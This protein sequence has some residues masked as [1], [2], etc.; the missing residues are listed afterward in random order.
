MN[1]WEG[2]YTSGGGMTDGS[3]KKSPFKMFSMIAVVLLV[4]G[5]TAS[6]FVAQQ[7]TENRSR[8]S[9]GGDYNNYNNCWSNCYTPT[10]TPTPKPTA[11]PTSTPTSTPTPVVTTSPTG[12]S[13]IIDNPNALISGS[14]TIGTS[15]IDKYGSDYRYTSG[16]S[17]SS[18][19]RYTPLIPTTGQYDVYEFHPA[20]LNRSSSAQHIISYSGG[21]QTISVNQQTNG[22]K[23]NFL[24]RFSFAQGSGGYV[25]ITNYGS[26]SYVVMADAIKFVPS[27]VIPTATPVPSSST[28]LALNKP[29]TA[30]SSCSTAE[31]PSQAVNGSWTGGSGDKWCS[32]GTNGAEWL[33]VDLGAFYNVSSFTIRHA[34]AGGEPTSYN[35]KSYT[36]QVSS[37]KVNWTTVVNIT[38]NT[39]NVSTNTISP[40]LARYVKLNV[41]TPEQAYADGSARIYEFEVYGSLASVTPTLIPTATPTPGTGGWPTATPTPR[42][43]A[44][45]TPV[46]TATP[47]PTATSTVAPTLTSWP[48]PTQKPIPT[49]V[50]IPTETP[51]PGDTILAFTVGLHGIG[52]GGD[53]TNPSSIGNMYPVHPQ[54][55]A[56]ADIYNTLNQLVETKQFSINFDSVSGKFKGDLNMGSLASGAYSVRIKPDQFLRTIVPGIQNVILGTTN[57]LAAVTITGGD[58]NNDNAVSILDYNILMGCYSDLM[59]ATDCPGDN[60]QQ[61][62]INDDGSV[63]QFDYNLFLRELSNRPGQ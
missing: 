41:L 35:T 14:W 20:G 38:N 15:S 49:E 10:A 48:T 22:G 4:A 39:S 61:A 25:Q 53:N 55:W 29:A 57:Q 36:I 2:S 42:P 3:K 13:I 23:W 19:V 62:D 37:D 11:T 17:G 58:I 50:I 1:D 33:Q 16:G 30:D 24:G 46:P 12:G 54:R 63:N 28:N 47:I 43:T 59:P 8:A 18:Y 9:W 31:I 7:S 5:V 56:T 27:S 32:H 34:G 52:K 45:P 51:M 6:V 21:S 44:T 26:S 40:A 60:A